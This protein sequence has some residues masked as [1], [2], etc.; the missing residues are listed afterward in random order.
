MFLITALTDF[1]VADEK[2][3]KYVITGLEPELQPIL[4][5]ENTPQSMDLYHQY[6]AVSVSAQPVMFTSHGSLCLLG[7]RGYSESQEGVR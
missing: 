7:G 6:S 5:N 3:P 1:P 2:S 4:P